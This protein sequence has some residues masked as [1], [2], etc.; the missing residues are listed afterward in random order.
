MIR[1]IEPGTPEYKRDYNAGW[2]YS[3]TSPAPNLEHADAIDASHAWLDGYM[4]AATGRHKW[5]Y[6][7][8]V[9]EGGQPQDGCL[10][11]YR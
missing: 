9:Y 4:D 3:L 11:E 8:C 1:R 7:R 5:H 10:P 6:L 2:R